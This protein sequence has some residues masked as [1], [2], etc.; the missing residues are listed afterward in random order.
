MT[1]PPPAV[2]VP[3]EPRA[4]RPAGARLTGLLEAFLAWKPARWP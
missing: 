2:P 4:K 1:A 3:S